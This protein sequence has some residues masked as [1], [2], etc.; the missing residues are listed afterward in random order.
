MASSSGQTKM[1]AICVILAIMLVGMASAASGQPPNKACVDKTGDVGGGC[2]C[3]TNCA[4]AGKC[5]LDKGVFDTVT[6]CFVNCVLK[7][8]CVCSSDNS[9]ATGPEAVN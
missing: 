1:V 6:D 4:C 5:I 9:S 3:S 8:D 2:I 7:N